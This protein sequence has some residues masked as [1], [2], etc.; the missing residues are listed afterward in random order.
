MNKIFP[1]PEA[2]VSDIP[3]GSS[4]AVGGF[5]MCGIP[6]VLITALHASDA[7]DLQVVSNN[8]GSDDYGL[9]V[10]L[11]DHRISRVIASYVGENAEFARQYLGGEVE[12]EL[13]PQSS[14]RQVSAH[15]SRTA[16]SLGGT[17]RTVRSRLGRPR[18]N[19]V[20]STGGPTPSKRRSSVTTP[21]C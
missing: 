7:T 3:N 4:L 20:S 11:G 10:L 13:T 8:C 17:D 6:M 19:S 21:W 9:G 5:G 18:K 1:S 12:V 2:A 16:D 15:W 14:R